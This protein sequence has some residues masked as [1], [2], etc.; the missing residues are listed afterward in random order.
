LNWFR[1]ILV[2][3]KSV[4]LFF[5]YKN[6]TKPKIITPSIKLIKLCYYDFKI[7]W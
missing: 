4:W 7:L 1:F 6:R 2:F 5:F 3:F